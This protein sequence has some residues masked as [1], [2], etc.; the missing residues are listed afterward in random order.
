[1]EAL[2]GRA[3]EFAILATLVDMLDERGGRWQVSAARGGECAG[4]DAGYAR[5]DCHW[6]AS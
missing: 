6:R 5:P 1:M 4:Q 3:R 2:V